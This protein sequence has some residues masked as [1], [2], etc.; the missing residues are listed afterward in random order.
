MEWDLRASLRG[1]SGVHGH[2]LH[3]PLQSVVVQAFITQPSPPL[4]SA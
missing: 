4:G 3:V 2:V 1:S